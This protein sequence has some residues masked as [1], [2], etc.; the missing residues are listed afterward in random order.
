MDQALVLEDAQAEREATFERLFREHYGDIL[1][2]LYRLVGDRK[3]AE[4]LTQDTF[5]KAYRAWPDLAAGANVR[6]WLYRIGTNTA[7]DRLRRRRLIAWL[8]LFE[9]DSHPAARTY[10]AEAALESMA[11][12]RALAQLP[13]RYRVPLVLFTCQGLSTFEIAEILH[14]S[15]GAVKT[16]LFRAREKFRRLYTPQ[17]V[18]E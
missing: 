3:E 8:P 1:A 4:D 13:A 10:F 9:R 5:L 6:A 15:Q 2:Y 12:Q 11:V 14:I 7:L 16:R 17:E 18:G